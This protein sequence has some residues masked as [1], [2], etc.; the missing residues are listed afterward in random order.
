MTCRR[1]AQGH[2]LT[3]VAKSLQLPLQQITSAQHGDAGPQAAPSSPQV[4]L[5][6]PASPPLL[7]GI[8]STHW[9]AW[10][11]D[12]TSW[13]GSQNAGKERS[14]WSR[15]AS[16]STRMPAIQIWGCAQFSYPTPCL[17]S[18]CG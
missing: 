7:G 17:L 3:Q 5:S 13:N 14:F 6:V 9:A 4:P 12:V 15:A 10:L 16:S 1:H 18:G 8:C 11:C 2:Y